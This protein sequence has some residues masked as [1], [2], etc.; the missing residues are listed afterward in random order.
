MHAASVA[1]A[2]RPVSR[3]FH[4]LIVSGALMSGWHS[5]GETLDKP[6]NDARNTGSHCF[7]NLA[8]ILYDLCRLDSIRSRALMLCASPMNPRKNKTSRLASTF[9]DFGD[10]EPHIDA[11]VTLNKNNVCR[12][13]YVLGIPSQSIVVGRLSVRLLIAHS[14]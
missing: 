8:A 9:S 11:I 14:G 12:A 4:L 3:A 6:L 2:R 10:R 1:V 13:K 7:A 5:N